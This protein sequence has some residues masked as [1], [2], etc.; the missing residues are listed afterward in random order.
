MPKR[1]VAV[2]TTLALLL[3]TC[4]TPAPTEVLFRSDLYHLEV[5]LPP[6]WVAAEGPQWLARPFTGLVAFN[7]WGES[8]FWAPAVTRG[9]STTYSPQSTLGQ[10]PEGGAYLALVHLSGGP[11]RQTDDYGP[12]YEHQDL[13]EL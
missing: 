11:P 10:V 12:E 6:G 4:G 5:T 1:Q 8:D 9:D 2:L 3:I 13:S 7:N